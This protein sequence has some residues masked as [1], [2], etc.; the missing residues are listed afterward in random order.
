MKLVEVLKSKEI[1]VGSASL[2]QLVADVKVQLETNT[3]TPDKKVIK[4]M[5]KAG[6]KPE[7]YPSVYKQVIGLV[8][9]TQAIDVA[10]ERFQ[11]DPEK[12]HKVFLPQKEMVSAC[13][14]K[15]LAGQDSVVHQ[16]VIEPSRK[17]IEYVFYKGKGL[18]LEGEVKNGAY[19]Q[20]CEA[21]NL[22]EFIK[23]CKVVGKLDGLVINE[24][25]YPVEPI[26]KNAAM[27]GIMSQNAFIADA[28]HGIKK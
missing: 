4:L 26:V 1:R 15:T 12:D 5:K 18:K 10:Y 2:K 25:E 6:V 9:G 20:E 11:F 23:A 13:G 22:S 7:D 17:L 3:L 21:K 28:Q 24:T 27:A 8:L 19:Y 14:A 16:S